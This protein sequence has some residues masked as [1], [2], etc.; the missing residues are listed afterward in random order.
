MSAQTDILFLVGLKYKDLLKVL[1][2]NAIHTSSYNKRCGKQQ[3]GERA[4]D[5]RRH[6]YGPAFTYTCNNNKFVYLTL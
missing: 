5:L 4:P 3:Q 1:L 2:V 6:P